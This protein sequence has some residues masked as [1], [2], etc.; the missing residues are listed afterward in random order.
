MFFCFRS[1]L[2]RMHKVRLWYLLH[3]NSDCRESRMWHFNT[4]STSNNLF[5]KLSQLQFSNCLLEL[6]SKLLT[7]SWCMCKCCSFSNSKLFIK[8]H[9]LQFSNYLLE[10]RSKLLTPSWCM[11]KRCSPTQRLD[12]T[13]FGISFAFGQNYQSN[14]C[15]TDRPV[16]GHIL[17]CD[18]KH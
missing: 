2:Q 12:S 11:C 13:S 16:L 7:P 1:R 3:R 5:S 10:L 4:T 6:R 15:G 14:V 9:Q 8:L 17:Y 18:S